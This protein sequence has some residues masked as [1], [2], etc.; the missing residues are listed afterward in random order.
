MRQFGRVAAQQFLEQRA[1]ADERRA[2]VFRVAVA[3]CVA[4]RDL[5]RGA[6]VLD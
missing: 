4:P 2:K 6:I 3:A 5:V 1:I